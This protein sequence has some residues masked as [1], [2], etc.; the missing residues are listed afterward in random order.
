MHWLRALDTGVTNPSD[1][2]E[3]GLSNFLFQTFYLAR[4]L[5]YNVFSIIVEGT[6]CIRTIGQAFPYSNV[7]IWEDNFDPTRTRDAYITL[8][9]FAIFVKMSQGNCL[10]ERIWCE[11][12]MKSVLYNCLHLRFSNMP[13][14]CCDHKTTHPCR[15]AFA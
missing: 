13:S 14:N 2:T 12:Q 7:P 8:L 10:S 4:K 6:V 9:L 3:K 5:C 1:T 15:C 11:K